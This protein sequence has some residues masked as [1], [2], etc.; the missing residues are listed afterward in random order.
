MNH[1]KQWQLK[2]LKLPLWHGKTFKAQHFF[3][4][5]LRTVSTHILDQGNKQLKSMTSL[6]L[7]L[8]KVIFYF[9]TIWTIILGWIYMNLYFFPVGFLSKSKNIWHSLSSCTLK[10]S[11]QAVVACERVLKSRW[12]CVPFEAANGDVRKTMPQERFDAQNIF[13]FQMFKY[14]WKSVR[15]WLHGLFFQLP[16]S[17][18]D[19][20]KLLWGGRA[21][22]RSSN[23]PWLNE[24]DKK[25]KNNSSWVSKP[26]FEQTKTTERL[27]EY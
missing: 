26:R 11:H 3:D 5:I 19:Q 22:N 27:T 14:N 10:C 23:A 1:K 16:W 4:K 15:D 18:D 17:L 13:G 9:P 25:K 24:T 20:L 12:N 2:L 21:S 6:F 8:F 7:D